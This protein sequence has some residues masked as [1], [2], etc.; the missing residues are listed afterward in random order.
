MRKVE[1]TEGW[2]SFLE[3]FVNLV[4]S[5][6][7]LDDIKSAEKTEREASHYSSRISQIYLML[8]NYWTGK[9]NEKSKEYFEIALD[10]FKTNL[11]SYN[12]IL[13]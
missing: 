3:V 10:I 12:I 11:E 6:L 8:G 9:N 4:G 5:Y 1:Y 13:I 7:S 2:N